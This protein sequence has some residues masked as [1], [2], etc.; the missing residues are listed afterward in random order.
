MS[1]Q[2][3]FKDLLITV[4]PEGEEASKAHDCGICTRVTGCTPV[5]YMQE[6]QAAQNFCGPCTIITGCPSTTYP[7]EALARFGPCTHCTQVTACTMTTTVIATGPTLGSRADLEAYKA[8]LKRHLEAVEAL[9]AG[10]NAEELDAL[11]KRLESALAEVRDRKSVLK[12]PETE[13][14]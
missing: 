2:F 9:T 11:E 13:E 7:L 10:P 8:D 12:G 5:T 3:H 14:A 6:A 1:R 4:V